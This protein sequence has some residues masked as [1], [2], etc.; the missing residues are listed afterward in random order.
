VYNV[1]AVQTSVPH[2]IIWNNINYTT[3]LRNNEEIVRQH[4]LK[5]KL[6]LMCDTY[7]LGTTNIEILS[8]EEDAS[9]HNIL[10]ALSHLRPTLILYNIEK[11]LL[12]TWTNPVLLVVNLYLIRGGANDLTDLSQHWKKT[13]TSLIYTYIFILIQLLSYIIECLIIYHNPNILP[14]LFVKN[15]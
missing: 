14:K 11:L 9:T 12:S 1:Y 4:D 2:T 15:M 7:R 5:R 6:P 3:N 8:Y 13:F 10:I